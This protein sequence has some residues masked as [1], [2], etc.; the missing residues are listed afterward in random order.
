MALL[1]DVCYTG[2]DDKSWHCFSIQWHCLY[3][4]QFRPEHCLPSSLTTSLL[5][6]DGRTPATMARNLQELELAS[7]ATL[8]RL[9]DDHYRQLCT[10][11]HVKAEEE[12]CAMKSRAF[13]RP[14]EL[15]LG[16]SRNQQTLWSEFISQVA[17]L[18]KVHL[19]C[20]FGS[21]RSVGHS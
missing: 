19:A 7:G 18:G 9:I 11:R 21:Q 10:Q 3:L 12:T 4:T 1:I 13:F 14:P 15:L 5:C 6:D 17:K 20:A 2:S 16:M 8:C